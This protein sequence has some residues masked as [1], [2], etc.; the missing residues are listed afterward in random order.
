M[1]TATHCSSVLDRIRTR[2]PLVHNI[3]NYVV[4]NNTA[5]ALLAIGASPAMVHAPEEVEEFVG[6]S[7]ALVINIGTLSSA[8]VR[9]MD[10]AAAAANARGVPWVLDPVGAGATRYRTETSTALA[11]LRPACI[12]GNASEIL[13][14]AGATAAKTKGVDSTRGSDEAL[15]AA[16]R[17]AQATGA[18]VAVT[19]ATDYVTDGTALLGL[20]N[21]HPLMA[22]VTGLGCTATA[23]IGAA[24]AV[25]P[26]RLAAAAAGL[27]FLALAGEIAA[28][29]SPGPGSL[30]VQL[31]D[32]LHRLDS[33]TIAKRLKIVG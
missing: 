9:A 19:G 31:L 18:I 17:L 25:E 11:H 6:L 24:L 1:F 29:Q 8:W 13:V 33:T 32:A 7:A 22:R 16:R 23:L 26:D 15:D 14:L 5:N 2:Q 21:G 28:E 3:T 30:Q 12:R 20:A 27:T 10:A 4:M